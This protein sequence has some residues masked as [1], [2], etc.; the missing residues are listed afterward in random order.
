MSDPVAKSSSSLCASLSA[1]PDTLVAFVRH[2]GKVEETV[3]TAKAVAIDSKVRILSSAAAEIPL[4][5]RRLGTQGLTIEY[6]AKSG[7]QKQTRVA[8]SPPLPSYSAVK[9]RL[10]QMQVAAEE[11][12]GVVSFHSS[13]IPMYTR[14]GS[15][16]HD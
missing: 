14:P 7:A 6:T 13:R 2:W 8:F 5:A 10:E 4:T 16:P 9:P 12:L 3:T 15:R 1:Q 11:A